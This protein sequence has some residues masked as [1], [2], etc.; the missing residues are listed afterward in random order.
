MQEITPFCHN[1]IFQQVNSQA[2]GSVPVVIE[3]LFIRT[4]PVPPDSYVAEVLKKSPSLIA[5]DWL[6]SLEVAEKDPM[7]DALSNQELL[8]QLEFFAK[9]QLFIPLKDLSKIGGVKS[10]WLERLEN[11]S[12]EERGALKQINKNSIIIQRYLAGAEEY[13]WITCVRSQRFSVLNHSAICREVEAVCEGF[14][15]GQ[16]A[17]QLITEGIVDMEQLHCLMQKILEQRQFIPQICITLASLIDKDMSFAERSLLIELLQEVVPLYP[18]PEQIRENICQYLSRLIEEA[19]LC[20]ELQLRATCAYVNLI[21]KKMFLWVPK[22]R[23]PIFTFHKIVDLMIKILSKCAISQRKDLLISMEKIVGGI[24][25][26]LDKKQIL[27]IVEGQ[28]AAFCQ[29]AARTIKPEFPAPMRGLCFDV[30]AEICKSGKDLDSVCEYIEQRL[31]CDENLS[32]EKIVR[33]VCGLLF[34]LEDPEEGFFIGE[35]FLSKVFAKLQN[36]RNSAAI[37]YIEN[38]LRQVEDPKHAAYL[39]VV[40]LHVRSTSMQKIVADSEVAVVTPPN[41]WRQILDFLE[42]LEQLLEK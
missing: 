29:M 38:A 3:S 24:T 17:L 35:D 36:G 19:L 7:L 22:D 11:L 25:E 21:E 42:R 37:R 9:L 23:C 18:D 26:A 13:S 15:K 1:S 10:A 28:S 2:S 4:D 40:V 33:Y 5:G 32:L 31:R 20:P 27:E 41:K 34:F 14:E 16:L 6:A 39:A 8:K 12:P 30:C